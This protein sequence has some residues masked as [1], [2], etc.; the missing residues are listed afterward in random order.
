MSISTNINVKSWLLIQRIQEKKL[1]K[2]KSQI[3]L[4]LQSKTFFLYY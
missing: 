2:R 4:S 3:K 1:R